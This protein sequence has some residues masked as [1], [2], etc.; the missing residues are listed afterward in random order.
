MLVFTFDEIKNIAFALPTVWL[1][2]VMG[3]HVNP[4]GSTCFDR[5]LNLA[6]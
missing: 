5:L 6:I 2:T 3:M 1:A 4:V